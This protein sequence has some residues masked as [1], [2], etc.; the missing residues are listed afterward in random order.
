MSQSF[1]ESTAIAPNDD[2]SPSQVLGVA[3]QTWKSQFEPPNTPS[4]TAFA[5]ITGESASITTV[6]DRNTDD[7]IFVR[8]PADWDDPASHEVVGGEQWFPSFGMPLG[9]DRGRLPMPFCNDNIILSED[10]LEV[11][12]STIRGKT[13]S[14]STPLLT[15]SSP[16]VPPKSL[17]ARAPFDLDQ[18]YPIL[19][20]STQGRDAALLQEEQLVSRFNTLLHEAA[21][22]VF[23]D[24]ME[25]AFSHGITIAI[26]SYG[27]IAVAAIARLIDADRADVETLGE[28][29]RQLGS[30]EDHRTHR[31]RLAI[32]LGRIRSLDP[33]I[34]DASSLGLAA[35]DDP[36]AL[37]AVQKA[38]GREASAQLRGNLQL[39]IDQLQ[40]TRWQAS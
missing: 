29:L 13:W 37:E 26:E 6:L 30:I 38:W 40:A 11:D 24:G 34:R 21:E 14:I 15:R 36:V 20:M 39:V 5:Q 9:Y 31:S 8:V 32:L 10:A 1:E 35:L 33:R 2:Y 7:L 3:L 4:A 22:Q 27:D 12:L 19:A 16:T 28:L 25:S 17:T 23:S 18:E